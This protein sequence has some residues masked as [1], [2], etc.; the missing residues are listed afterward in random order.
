MAPQS[1]VKLDPR[2]ASAKEVLESD[3]SK[4][5]AL[6]RE[7]I[8]LDGSDAEVLKAKEQ[9]ISCLCRSFVDSSDA[10]GL[11]SL[12]KDLL[13][14]YSSMPKAKTAKIVRTVIDALARV[15]KSEAL[16]VGP[17]LVGAREC[18]ALAGT[19]VDASQGTLETPQILPGDITP[20][21][22]CW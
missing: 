10:Q 19:S 18:V 15:P 6:L 20:P 14:L 2:V 21:F 7:V 9:A 12:L 3:Q 17:C 4:G 22:E 13:P 1:E 16:Q 8:A 11:K 5:R